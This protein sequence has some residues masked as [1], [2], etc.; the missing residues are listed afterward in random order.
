[1]SNTKENEVRRHSTKS[2]RE[3]MPSTTSILGIVFGIFMFIVYEGMGVLMFINFF[4]W[5]GDWEW[6]RWVVGAVL[7]VYGFFRGYRTYNDVRTHG[8]T[9][10]EE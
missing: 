4:N 1:M 6:T 3:S 10:N 2:V 8:R 7:V 9:D 5:R